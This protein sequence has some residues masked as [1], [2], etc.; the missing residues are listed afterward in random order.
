ME[1]KPKNTFHPEVGVRGGG[2]FKPAPAP[3]GIV[4]PLSNERTYFGNETPAR[5]DP[6]QAIPALSPLT[7]QEK[8]AQQV[9]EKPDTRKPVDVAPRAVPD[10]P[11]QKCEHAT[12]IPPRFP[13]A[14]RAP[15]ATHYEPTP[16]RVT[17]P[18]NI[19]Q[20]N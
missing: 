7:E 6:V 12:V 14:I 2:R 8:Q 10:P 16:Q 18:R 9:D 3:A 4:K 5:I 20:S 17:K 13:E 1:R 11:S 15:E 19:P